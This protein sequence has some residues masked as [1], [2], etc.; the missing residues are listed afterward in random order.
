MKIKFYTEGGKNI[1]FGHINRCLSLAQAFTELK[2]ECEF[3]IFG[4]NSIKNIVTNFD[5]NITDWIFNQ[6]N[7]S[8]G[9]DPKDILVI[10]SY[11]APIELINQ[12]VKL[13]NN[14]IF[15]DDY[16]RIN[17]PL[18]LLINGALNAEDIYSKR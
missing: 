17:Y 18:G 7:I 3:T 11:N 16:N 9:I 5:V 14:L 8:L 12:I 1:G 2:H 4:D 6:A 15:F 10:D 13:N